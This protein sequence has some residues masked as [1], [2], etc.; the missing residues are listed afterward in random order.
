VNR[1]LGSV[2]SDRIGIRR[3]DKV[4]ATSLH[5]VLKTALS[6]SFEVSTM[7]LINLFGLL[8]RTA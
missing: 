6:N 8:Y 7:Y 4:E 1:H 2:A 3:R 5:P